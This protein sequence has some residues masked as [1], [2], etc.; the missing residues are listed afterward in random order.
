MDFTTTQSFDATA[1]EVFECYRSAKLVGALPGFG[2]LSAAEPLSVNQLDGTTVVRLRYRFVG[3]LPSAALAVVHP[4]K[5][6]WVEE[7]TYDHGTLRAS[8]ALLPDYYSNKL[9][10]SA[11][12]LF[13]DVGTGSTRTVAG[14]MKVRV[15][16][17]GGQVERVI[18]NGLVEYL[19][20][21]AAHVARYLAHT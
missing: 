10:A 13:D 6:T 11:R 21:E 1:A 15:P 16:L 7:T 8:V 17:V 2:P 9:Q 14:S 20:E 19:D 12:V 4:S 5:L 18:V 3:D